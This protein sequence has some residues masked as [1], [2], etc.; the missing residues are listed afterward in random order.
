M[1]YLLSLLLCVLLCPSA[2][3]AAAQELD[4]RW[5]FED[6]GRRSMSLPQHRW[7]DGGVLLYDR[8]PEPAQRRLRLFDP[9]SGELRE[10]V[11]AAAATAAM[12]AA[13]APEEPVEEIGWPDAVDSAGLRAAYARDGDIALLDL[14]SGEITVIAD[15]D[16]RESAPRFSPD[17]RWLAF[18]RGND[19]Y[20]WNIADGSER[21]LTTDG[22]ATRRNGRLSW[23]YWEEFMGRSERGFL[24]APDSSAIA[25]LQ[26]DEAGVGEMH[27]VDF[28][29][30]LPRVI[31][32]RHPKAG[33]DNPRVR[34]GVVDLESAVTTWVDLGAYPYEYLPRLQWLPGSA[35]VAV[36]TLNRAQTVLDLFVADAGSGA[37]R[38]VLR[39][40]SDSWIDVHDD[41]H[42]LGD[43]GEFLW[44]STRDG[45]ARLYRFDLDG[46]LLAAVT[47]AGR[48]LRASGAGGGRDRAVSFIDRAA[49]QVYYTALADDAT[50]RAL[51]RA[52]LDGGNAT[53]I[54]PAPGVHAVRFNAA[55]GYF[56]DAHSALGRLPALHLHDAGGEHL[57]QL[58]R[59]DAALPEQ[60]G[61]QPWERFEIATADDFRMPAM[62][63]KPRDFDPARRYPAI[64]HVYAGPSAPTVVDRWRGGA[65]GLFHQLLADSGALVF[66]VDN[67]SAAGRSQSDAASILRR[68]YGEVE[69]QDLLDGVAWLQRQDFVDPARIGVWGWSGGG[70]MTLSAL[71]G[72]EVF[73]AGIAVAPVTDWDYY[74]TVYTERYMKR[75]QDNPEGYAATS[76]VERAADLHGRLLLVHGTYDDNVHPQNA[77]AFSDALIDAGITFDMLIYPMRKHGISDDAAQAHLYRSM[78]E[79]WQ[80]EFGLPR[81]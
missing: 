68:L 26:S 67:R 53:I 22:S 1:P 65:R 41:L 77:W 56:L 30:A 78:L 76:L 29:P 16:A 33:A 81:R 38:H 11:D 42:F 59:I 64:V 75:P 25:Y 32:Q 57:S 46:E 51:Y 34:A 5:I 71:T 19:I 27:Y 63:L 37:V 36:Q 24:W 43:G 31:H 18:L 6:G 14:R 55:G 15:S 44:R 28:A 35:R 73:H 4:L 66:L 9:A 50:G 2:P 48:M 74:D 3:R 70:T 72:S 80:R 54:T 49:R 23:V 8:R 7:V 21:R 47:P 60:L 69:L 58:A 45:H 20:A 39:E 40:R 17:G 13:L 10:P 61:W 79:F 52:D 12:N 62:L